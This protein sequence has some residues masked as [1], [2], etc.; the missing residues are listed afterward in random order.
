MKKARSFILLCLCA[1]L[2]LGT[3]FAAE[4]DAIA[5]AAII[6][7]EAGNPQHVLATGDVI[8]MRVY[9][10]EDL[11]TRAA[12]G[13]DG[14]ITIPLLGKVRVGGNTA[15]QAAKAIHAL[16]EKD[17]L[18]NPQ[19]NVT[20]L[21][22]AKKTFNIL[23]HVAKP[24]TYDLPLDGKFDILAAISTAGG[25]GRLASPKKVTVQRFTEGKP[26]VLKLDVEN[27]MKDFSAPRFIIQPDDTINIGER[28]F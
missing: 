12:V 8:E 1:L 28:L 23:G 16:L 4:P 27:M 2:A 3:V 14:T 18:V 13:T 6:L 5:T 25:F 26:Q 17:Y 22:H 20:I 10:E 15:E 19:V 24:G 21:E 9:Q 11:L 7:P